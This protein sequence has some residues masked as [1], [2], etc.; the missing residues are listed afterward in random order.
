[1][2]SQKIFYLI[3]VLGCVLP[4]TIPYMDKAVLKSQVSKIEN[5]TKTTKVVKNE[6]LVPEVSEAIVPVAKVKE[7]EPVV[8]VQKV[9]V[10]EVKKEKVQTIEQVQNAKPEAE[11]VYDGMTLDQ[12]AAQLDKSL[13]STL[14]GK[15]FLYASY[16]LQMG[17]DPYVALAITLHE[18]GCNGNC[19]KLVKECN[20]VG[21]MKG[22]P[23][24]NGG[25]YKKFN[26]IDD[27]IKAYIDNLSKNYYK[28]GLNTV[29]KINKK[30]A[31]STAWSGKIY[32]YINL[33]KTR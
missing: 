18:T 1:M 13:K 21:G 12:L 25:S 4:L 28:K 16:S 6:P 7:P 9:E 26:T 11:I 32:Y 29:E 19:S 20:N 31:A 17:V 5:E 3:L 14:T 10:K 8:E 2:R 27:G 23:G 24:C 30:Y 33:I 15:G 22:S